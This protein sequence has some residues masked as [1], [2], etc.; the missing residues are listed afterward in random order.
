[1]VKLPMNFFKLNFVSRIT[2][3][4]FALVQIDTVLKNFYNEIDLI[5]TRDYKKIP[6]NT[7]RK[8]FTNMKT[9][10]LF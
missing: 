1:M 7:Y 8:T 3:T 10:Q 6:L 2:S 5:K 9:L 4:F